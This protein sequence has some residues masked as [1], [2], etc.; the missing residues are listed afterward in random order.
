VLWAE[1]VASLM[2]PSPHFSQFIAE[3]E[4]LVREHVRLNHPHSWEEDHITRSLLNAIRSRFSLLTRLVWE[5]EP[6]AVPVRYNASILCAWRMKDQA[7]G[8]AP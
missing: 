1:A 3:I 6:P 8:A 2:A 7:A 5:D 4:L